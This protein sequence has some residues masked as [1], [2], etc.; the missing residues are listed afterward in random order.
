DPSSWTRPGGPNANG[1]EKNKDINTTPDTEDLD[2]NTILDISNNYLEYTIDLSDSSS[3]FL[4]TDVYK[5]YRNAVPNLDAKWPNGW[6]LYRIPITAAQ[7]VGNPNL[8]LV[9]HARVWLDG[10]QQ[11]DPTATEGG[12]RPLVMLGGVDIVGS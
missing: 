9:K 11:S 8:A 2:L 7:R 4:L 5:T 10:I 12:P 3:S 1:T 6:R